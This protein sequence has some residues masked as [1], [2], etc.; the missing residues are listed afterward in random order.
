MV[1]KRWSIGKKVV[2][3]LSVI[4]VWCHSPCAVAT[5]AY[6]WHINNEK[7]DYTSANESDEILFSIGSEDLWWQTYDREN[8]MLI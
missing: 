2:V 3:W 7:S 5:T 8:A 6:G 4:M 1:R